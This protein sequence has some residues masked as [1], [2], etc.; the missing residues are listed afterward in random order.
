MLYHLKSRDARRII[1]KAANEGRGDQHQM[2]VRLWNVI[3]SQP[4]AEAAFPR[5]T[6]DPEY[7]EDDEFDFRRMVA[8]YERAH[9]GPVSK[10]EEDGFFGRLKAKLFGSD[11]PT[12]P[13]TAPPPPLAPDDGRLR[14]S[15]SA[16]DAEQTDTSVDSSSGA[17]QVPS[18]EFSEPEPAK[19]LGPPRAGMRIEA[20]LSASGG[21][22]SGVLPMTF[23][24]YPDQRAK[25]PLW[26][27]SRTDVT[28]TAGRFEVLLGVDDA[29][30]PGLP[31]KVWLGIEI[32]G[33]EL[34]P[35]SELSRYRSV[36]QG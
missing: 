31:E 3:K 12:E 7:T 16:R 6:H 9:G 15:D 8:D 30:L 23:S 36:I 29:R 2:A 14:P 5:S 13:P 4:Y 19:D 11:A 35:R 32:E 25:T 24:I 20:V 34:E 1:Y 28:V 21:K 33:D 27:E 10:G 26:V 18:A 17:A 22:W